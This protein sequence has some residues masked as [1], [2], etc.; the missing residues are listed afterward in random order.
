MQVETAAKGGSTGP[1]VPAQTVASMC[2][3]VGADVATG[4]KLAGH[5]PEDYQY[6]VT[7]PPR[8]LNILSPLAPCVVSC[9]AITDAVTTPGDDPRPLVV[10]AFRE[11]AAA[12]RRLADRVEQ[13]PPDERP[14]YW[15]GYADALRALADE[16]TQIADVEA[17]Y[18]Q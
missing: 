16:Q 2:V 7:S 13:Q 12:N 8:L 3:A 5:D 18:G 6:L 17:P 15:S 10:S 1:G 4:L 11:V 9:R 14:D